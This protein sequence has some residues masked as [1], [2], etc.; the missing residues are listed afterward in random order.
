MLITIQF[1]C[2]E[3]HRN[4]KYVGTTHYELMIGKGTPHWGQLD[5]LSL[6]EVDT[7][8]DGDVMGAIMIFSFPSN[9]VNQLKKVFKS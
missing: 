9:V 2:K 8:Q 6:S 3:H 5:L 1:N 4:N 7:D